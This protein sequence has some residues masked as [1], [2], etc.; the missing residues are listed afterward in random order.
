MALTFEIGEPGRPK[1][2]A[3]VYFRSG[4]EILATYVLV[5]PITMDVGKYLPPLL[6]S[7][8]G[9]AAGELMGEGLGSFAAPPVP[10]R[11]ESVDWL[12][13]L[14]RLRS[15]DLIAGGD[16]VL[17]DVAS[18]MHETAQVVQEYTR[19]FQQY[20]GSAPPILEQQPEA[21]TTESAPGVQDVL[22]GL[23]SDRDKLG[24]LSKLV[25]T[26][27]FA[28]DRGDGPLADESDASIATLGRLLPEHYWGDRVRTAA[29]DMS[30]NGARLAQLYV[31]RCYKLLDE[32]FS[33]V[34]D[35]ERR[36]AELGT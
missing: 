5:L 35:L 33:A 36:I 10:E 13:N 15:D 14:A 24:E 25:G 2:H 1:G 34:T 19:L 23:M 29:R 26:L 8:L 31:E 27:R 6:A 4:G 28:T 12:E 21:L 7:Q 32:D 16:V 3:I 22:F 11:A 18:A 17:G 30:D 9:G 20:A